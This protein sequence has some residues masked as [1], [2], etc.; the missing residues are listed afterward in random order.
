MKNLKPTETATTA[1]ALHVFAAALNTPS[2]LT[3]ERLIHAFLPKIV[4]SS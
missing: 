4:H 1:I 3:A 2:Y